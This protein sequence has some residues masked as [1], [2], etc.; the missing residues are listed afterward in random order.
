M[1]IQLQVFAVHGHRQR[2][3][4]LAVTFG[5]INSVR[6][7]L[8]QCGTMPD[9]QQTLNHFIKVRA[10]FGHLS[11][12]SQHF[13]CT[14]ARHD[15]GQF[16]QST[17]VHGAQ[18]AGYLVLVDIAF[19]ERNR[20]VGQTEGVTHTALCRPAQLPQRRHFVLNAF[21]VQNGFQIAN[22]ALR[23]HVLETELQTTRQHSDRQLLRIGG[24]QQEF[25]V[26]WR[27]FQ[28]FQQGVEA[29]G[30]EHV[31]FVDQVN[32]VAASRRCVLDVV[33]QFAGV[34]NLGTGGSIHF[35]QINKTAFGNL[36]TGRTFATRTRANALFAVE[37]LGKNSGNGGF[38]DPT[39]TGKQIGMVQTLLV[40][41]VDQRSQDVLLANH[42]VEE[43]WPP[44]TCKYLITH[45]NADSAK[46]RLANDSDLRGGC[47]GKL[48]MT[49]ISHTPAHEST[50]TVAPFRAWRGSQF[51]VA[52]GPTGAT[53]T[54][55]LRQE[56]RILMTTSLKIKGLFK[57]VAPRDFRGYILGT[58]NAATASMPT[59]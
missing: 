31:H 37:A 26:L 32:L 14:A 58:T 40:K 42:F 56:A 29:V 8:R 52:R 46:L 11:H 1:I 47:Q 59:R 17:A 3:N 38:T 21:S 45:E 22:N 41:G 6:H 39:G 16:E 19:A 13:R 35:D 51:I 57:Q 24:C 33:E 28:R 5:V 44:F 25:D 34:L 48:E 49:P 53:I 36:T 50:T 9:T 7:H 15:F 18:H 2:Q 43:L 55:D 10:V 54:P 20:L 23:R 12:F 27:L 4:G 30:R